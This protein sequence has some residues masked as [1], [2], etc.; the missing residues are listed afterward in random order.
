[1]SARA[2]APAPGAAP[3]PRQTLRAWISKHVLYLPTQ[4]WRGEPVPQHLADLERSQWERPEALRAR[5]TERALALVSHAAR[6]V[7]HYRDAWRAAG[8][9]PAAFR[10]LDDLRRLPLLEK[11]VMRA[12]VRRLVSETAAV[13]LDPRKTS[14]STGIPVPILKSRDAYARIRAIWYR[15]ARWYGIDIG[16]RQGRFLGHPVTWKG[17][18]REDVQDFILN[19]F[20]LDPVYL[21]PERMERYWR[22]ILRRP[23]VYL[24]GYASAMVAFA[25]HLESVGEDPRR[26]GIRTLICTGET[27][28]PFQESHLRHAFGVPVVNEYG[29]TESGVL[30]FPCP[31]AGRMHL[32]ADNV[33]L[34][35][36]VGDRPAKPGEAGEVV[37]TDLY[38]PEVPLIR[39]RL[40]DVAVPS[41]GAP[42]A[43]GRGLPTIERV[44]GRTSQMIVLPG[45]RAVHS[46]VFAYI[47]D[48]MGE[49]DRRIEGFRV[50]KTGDAAFTV[51]L[52]AQEPLAPATLDTLRG[53][54][55]RV[56]GPQV[57]LEVEQVRELPRDPSGKLR[58]FVDDTSAAA[59]ARPGEA[60]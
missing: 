56:L 5:Q 21:T 55:A 25:R 57:E 44:E 38:S 35:F 41:D 15:Y 50:R 52:V 49:V 19:K 26:A 37:L 54:V 48:A 14:G 6:H 59:A 10:S 7:P 45:G 60:R 31:E 9:D 46:E 11:D 20:R 13:P 32:S 30:A 28:Y 8:A 42:C 34:E 27:L 33:L 16:D 40:G 3:L 1:M 29:C 4:R 2:Q 18:L 47:S 43:C 58:Y 36:L 17:V 12:N 39:Y 22:K 51:Q 23:V 24:Y 53:I